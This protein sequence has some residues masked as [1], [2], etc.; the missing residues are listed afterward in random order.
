MGVDAD[1]LR[2]GVGARSKVCRGC[3][4]TKGSPG[5]THWCQ[6][7][8]VKAPQKDRGLETVHLFCHLPAPEMRAFFI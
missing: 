3:V 4:Q 7:H 6:G 2:W 8:E 1:H 5:L